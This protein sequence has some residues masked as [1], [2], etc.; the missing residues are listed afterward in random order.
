MRKLLAVFSLAVLC[1]SVVMVGQ[2]GPAPG[3]AA[4]APR[5]QGPASKE[6]RDMGATMMISARDFGAKGDGVADDTA[7]IQKA[8]DAAA[9]RQETVYLPAG[10][11]LCS[12]LKLRPQTGLYGHPN[13]SYRANGGAVLK[14][15]DTNARCLLDLTGAIGATIEGSQRS[16][17]VGK[18]ESYK[19]LVVEIVKFFKSGKPPVSAEETLEIFAFME[20][21]DESRRQGGA[22]V[23]LKDVLAKARSAAAS[24]N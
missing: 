2:S 13:F 24:K 17:D 1:A 12:T 5:G 9:A 21:A 6:A 14:L 20:A 15:N 3:P 8:I 7:A 19:P 11:Y 22:P 16:G 18:F 23:P 4:A 10:T